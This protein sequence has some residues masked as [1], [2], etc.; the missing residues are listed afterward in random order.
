MKECGFCHE[1]KPITAFGV[2]NAEKDKLNRY[3]KE[4][5]RKKYKVP[6]PKYQLNITDN[7][8]YVPS[9]RGSNKPCP[10]C[11][12]HFPIKDFSRKI[13]SVCSTVS[14]AKTRAK[15]NH[16]FF[17]ELY[18]AQAVWDQY[19][20]RYLLAKHTKIAW[21]VDHIEPLNTE[22]ICGV[23]A[24]WNLQ[25]IPAY[26]HFEKHKE[27]NNIVEPIR[28]AVYV[29]YPDYEQGYMVNLNGTECAN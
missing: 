18:D 8:I 15:K 7:E 22:S 17:E 3:C 14:T 24:H 12:T 21:H 11:H 9:V 20:I 6:A 13:C 28:L 29:Q 26:L 2:N 25:L 27:G 16:G 5:V 1:I 4:C 10:R 23:H 19:Y